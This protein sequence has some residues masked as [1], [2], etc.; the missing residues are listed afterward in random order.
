MRIDAALVKRIGRAT[1]ITL[2]GAAILAAA[3][4]V[5]PRE[6]MAPIPAQAAPAADPLDA[7]LARCRAIA[8]PEDVDD[9]CRAA[10]AELR[11]RFFAPHDASE[12]RP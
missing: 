12:V 5:R 6:R 7:E 3:I 2:L 4:S 10:W 11:R 8:R 9:A 1:A